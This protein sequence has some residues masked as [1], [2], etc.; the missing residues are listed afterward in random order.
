MTFLSTS[1]VGQ[2]S[3]PLSIGGGVYYQQQTLIPDSG[4]YNFPNTSYTP[5][6]SFTNTLRY[7]NARINGKYRENKFEQGYFNFEAWNNNTFYS[8]DG[9]K[10]GVS[11]SVDS[12]NNPHLTNFWGN[13]EGTIGR[14]AIYNFG[15]DN[16]SGVRPKN[17]TTA[18]ICSGTGGNSL[19]SMKAYIGTIPSGAVTIYG[20][21]ANANR[22]YEAD[23]TVLSFSTSSSVSTVA[24]KVTVF[25]FCN[26]ASDQ[27]GSGL[28]YWVNPLNV[29]TNDNNYANVSLSSTTSGNVNSNYLLATNFGLTIPTSADIVG[30]E[31]VIKRFNDNLGS[32][33]VVSD[34]SIK[35][36]VGGSITGNDIDSGATW[37]TTLTENTIGGPTTLGGLSLTPSQLNANNFGVAIK[38]NLIADFSDTANAKIDSIK[39][40]VYYTQTTITPTPVTASFSLINRGS[41]ANRRLNWLL[42]ANGASKY[43]EMPGYIYE[44]NE[45]ANFLVTYSSG[46]G[47]GNFYLA[48]DDSPF[49]L[50]NVVTLGNISDVFNGNTVFLDDSYVKTRGV[51]NNPKIFTDFGMSNRLWSSLDI[52]NFDHHR[53]NPAYFITDS[54]N[55]GPISS[56]TDSTAVNFHFPLRSSGTLGSCSSSGY[57][58]TSFYIPLYSGVSSQLF[59][60]DRTQFNPNA[61]ILDMWV[62]NE[63]TNPSG[64]INARIDFCDNYQ[65]FGR[66]LLVTKHYWSGFPVTVEQNNPTGIKRVLMSGVMYDENHNPSDLNNVTLNQANHAGLYLGAWYD[67][68]GTTYSGDISVYSARVYVDGWLTPQ[69]VNSG[70]SLYTSGQQIKTEF[71]D[72]V[73]YNVQSPPSGTDLYIRGLDSTNSGI[74]LYIAGSTETASM[75]LYINSD[76]YVQSSGNAPLY[77]WG[78]TNS[79]ISNS[80]SLFV[81]DNAPSGTKTG[82]MNLCLLGPYFGTATGGMNL[83]LDS[84]YPTCSS[85][86]DLVCYNAYT[87]SNSGISLYLSAPSGT[88][89]AVP[90]SGWMNL[91]IARDSEAIDG[92]IPLYIGGPFQ[93]SGSIPLYILGGTPYFSSIPLYTDGVGVTENSVKLYT[94]GF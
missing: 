62:R 17:I 58:D 82:N 72:L 70:I 9:T 57:K 50:V 41:D 49:R 78:T 39:T 63:G 61:L 22:E 1:G 36:I 37:P 3:P 60:F 77:I 29:Y 31:F 38:A 52:E 48:Y 88:D 74:P 65:S 42:K 59:E 89:G 46:T 16:A 20:R 6:W 71:L 19:T 92:G 15:F 26:T 8:T 66:E 79:G 84:D 85:G 73:L 93:N 83:F 55:N 45:F 68:I 34:N 11:Y 75:N 2:Y 86:I 80:I 24:N 28:Y 32:A 12:G 27:T 56:G 69:T 54:L 35:F 64:N 81:G 44:K 90:I 13:N 14:E 51:E 87:N 30:V 43:V 23:D 76:P 91:F 7:Q 25:S 53:L 5:N 40:R 33:G 94:H 18:V 21:F 4:L 10:S 67:N 47:V